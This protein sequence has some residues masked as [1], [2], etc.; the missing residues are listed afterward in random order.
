MA[1]GTLG[2]GPP[3][4]PVTA[5]KDG[6]EC[7]TQTAGGEA[8]LKA[9]FEFSKEHYARTGYRINLLSVGYRILED[10]SSLFSYSYHGTVIT[11]EYQSA[12]PPSK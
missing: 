8:A 11:F 6:A 10:Q 2:P 1:R 5:N 7:A 4:E 3:V 12:Y 9:Y